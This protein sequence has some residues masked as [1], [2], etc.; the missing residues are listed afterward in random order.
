M[1]EKWYAV[2]T[3]PRWEKKVAET[4]TLKSIKNYCPLNKVVHQWS[5][6]KK[7]VHVPLFTSYVFVHVTERQFMEL[8]KVNGVI[9]IV[10]W[11][12]KPA[13]IK[14]SEIESIKTFLTDHSN[15]QLEIVEVNVNDTIQITQG[16]LLD[17][18]GTIV[19]IKKNVI[20]VALPSLGY[21]LYAEVDKSS[22]SRVTEKI[23]ISC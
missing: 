10:T 9:S 12:N 2:Y 8:K 20:K 3:R 15:V 22:V 5:D 6:R 1:N 4:L 11:L 19:A 17:K 21:V 14:D 23:T 18:K 16:S 7:T 13:V